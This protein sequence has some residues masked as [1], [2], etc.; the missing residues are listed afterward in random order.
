MKQFLYFESLVYDSILADQSKLGLDQFG[1]EDRYWNGSIDMLKKTISTN[2]KDSETKRELN[3]KLEVLIDK[4]QKKLPEVSFVNNLFKNILGD[5]PMEIVEIALK[6]R[7]ELVLPP[8]NFDFLTR[9]GLTDP[10]I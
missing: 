10:V 3:F 6:V 4:A 9:Q 8:V 2:I 1:E 7:E 5:F